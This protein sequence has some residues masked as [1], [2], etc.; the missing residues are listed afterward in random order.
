MSILFYVCFSFEYTC[1]ESYVVVPSCDMS[2]HIAVAIAK[3]VHIRV[4]LVDISVSPGS[5]P[6]APQNGRHRTVAFGTVP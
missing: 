5:A 1:A 2:R 4:A 6:P 3:S